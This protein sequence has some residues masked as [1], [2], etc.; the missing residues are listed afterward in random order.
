VTQMTCKE[1]EEVVHDFVR[2]EMLD[3]NEREAVLEHTARCAH[4]SQRLAAAIALAEASQTA[5]ESAS[6]EQVPPRIEAVLLAAFREHHRRVSWRR[7]FE[8]VGV[9]AAAAVLLA[10]LWTTIGSSKQQQTPV[11]KKDPIS[12][13]GVPLDANASSV[14]KPDSAAQGASTL[15][16]DA[17][18][19]GTY[20]ASDFVP[21]PFAGAVTADDP[22]MIV[23]VQL[24]RASLAQLG[25]PLAEAPDEE[26]ISADVLVG[27]DGWP[28]GVKL[29]H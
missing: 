13:S 11:Q 4:C 23:R 12:Q 15:A 9:G 2:M 29:I 1:F 6:E 18:E 17:S 27:E 19:G 21:V 20:A 7:A 3:V 8:W 22:G 26:L 24:T 16:A 14:P 5:G 28:R 10:F 25:Y